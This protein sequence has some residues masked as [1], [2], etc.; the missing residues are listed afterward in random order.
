MGGG[1]PFWYNQ[2]G[3][4][5]GE[6]DILHDIVQSIDIYYTAVE[7]INNTIAE[8]Q[9]KINNNHN[10]YEDEVYPLSNSLLNHYYSIYD[11]WRVVPE[12]NIQGH[13]PDYIVQK[14][15][16]AKVKFIDKIY[17]EVKRPGYRW[18]GE[19]GIM[20]QVNIA[21]GWSKDLTQESFVICIVGL[22]IGFF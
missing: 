5:G 3:G 11:N 22:D 8:I 15:K 6:M 10:L 7:S 9:N 2:N 18:L 20:K 1:P 16:E 13:I 4:E 17:V 21:S 12:T 19:T 14:F